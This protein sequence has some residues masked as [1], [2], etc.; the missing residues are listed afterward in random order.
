[1]NKRDVSGF[2]HVGEALL[3]LMEIATLQGWARILHVAMGGRP[4]VDAVEQAPA[5]EGG[6][7]NGF[8]AGAF[9]ATFVLLGGFMLIK[10][11]AGVVIDTFNRLRDER[12]RGRGRLVRRV[13]RP[14]FV[15]DGGELPLPRAA[16]L[17]AAPAR[18]RRAPRA[19]WPAVARPTTHRANPTSATPSEK[20]KHGFERSR[21]R[22]RCL[23]HFRRVFGV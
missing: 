4:P 14:L 1:M 12:S 13:R 6:S 22:C 8:V 19:Y 17:P 11:F 18:R 7:E 9:F 10:L 15:G 5:A 21:R 3:T 2:D 23:C 16:R 20:A